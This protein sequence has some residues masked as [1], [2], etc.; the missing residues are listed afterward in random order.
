MEMNNYSP[1][2]VHD[3]TPKGVLM[4]KQNQPLVMKIQS[5]NKTLLTIED[6]D[7][8]LVANYDPNDLDEATQIFIDNLLKVYVK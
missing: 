3:T 6:K 2:V 4:V 7:G 1:I 8:K 5:Q